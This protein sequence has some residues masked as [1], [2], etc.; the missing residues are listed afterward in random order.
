[1]ILLDT[2]GILAA[3][4]K[5]ERFHRSTR[6]VLLAEAQPAVMSPLVLAESDYLLTRNLG[7][8]FALDL[9]AEVAVGA[10]ELAP[11][12]REDVGE[13][14]RVVQHF[15][16]LG[17]GLTD[18]SIVVLAERYDCNRVLTLDERHFRAL[19]TLNGRPFTLLPADA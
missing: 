14:V 16:N 3:L 17:I 11:L 15:L 1:M 19:R 7:P 9:A 10:Y 4:D 5:S 6:D 12:D 13:A 18:A 2:S 8:S